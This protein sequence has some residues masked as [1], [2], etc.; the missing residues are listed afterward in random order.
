[1]SNVLIADKLTNI[2]PEQIC[3]SVFELAPVP[4]I[5]VD[6][7]FKIVMANK[8]VE[9][10]FGFTKQDLVQED[11]I[12]FVP[13]RY[14]ELVYES[15]IVFMHTDCACKIGDVESLYMRN[16]IGQEINVIVE[17]SKVDSNDGLYFMATI[18]NKGTPAKVT[19]TN[20][21]S[22]IQT[23]VNMFKALVELSNEATM[24]FNIYGKLTF[25]SSGTEEL[26]GYSIGER[27]FMNAASLCHHDDLPEFFKRFEI[28]MANPGQQVNVCYR[29]KHKNGPYIGVVGTIANWLHEDNVNAVIVRLRDVR[30][31]GI[32]AR[33]GINSDKT[34]ASTSIPFIPVIANMDSVIV[35]GRV[36]I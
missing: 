27:K 1:M 9:D 8:S 4:M 3:N 22:G 23:N 21:Q 28:A 5:I 31:N 15:M 10:F 19:V 35:P 16:K 25:Q 34:A 29:L 6:S 14:K 36:G 20:D 24:M 2:F 11:I 18:V 32:F 7:N 33:R 17:F 30:T 12:D 13:Y 26:M